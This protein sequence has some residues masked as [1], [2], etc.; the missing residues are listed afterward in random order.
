MYHQKSNDFESL[1]V[2]QGVFVRGGGSER[3]DEPGPPSLVFSHHQQSRITHS[4][5]PRSKVNDL[6]TS[7]NVWTLNLGS[8]IH[9]ESS[10]GEWCSLGGSVHL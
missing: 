1:N 3:K 7:L 8:V 9:G 5:S 4:G 2:L 10:I 6:L